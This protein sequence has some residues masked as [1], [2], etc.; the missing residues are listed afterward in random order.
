MLFGF[1]QER[2]L[3]SGSSTGKLAALNSPFELTM[4]S[5]GSRFSV[6]IGQGFQIVAD[7]GSGGRRWQPRLAVFQPWTFRTPSGLPTTAE[8][9]DA[10]A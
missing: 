3:P 9:S 1:L 5:A 4:A 8:R 10:D 2:K 6:A 7:F